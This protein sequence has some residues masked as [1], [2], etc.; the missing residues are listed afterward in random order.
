MCSLQVEGHNHWKSSAPFVDG[1]YPIC[2][3][4]LYAFSPLNTNQCAS[5]TS[6]GR[7]KVKQGGKEREVGR[8]GGRERKET[9]LLVLA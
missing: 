2:S 9:N 7:E 5:G 1:G 6:V 4:P 3:V 8:D